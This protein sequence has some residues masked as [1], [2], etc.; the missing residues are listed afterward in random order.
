MAGTHAS[1]GDV[2]LGAL[3]LEGLRRLSV[4]AKSKR[5]GAARRCQGT[6]VPDDNL[7]LVDLDED[8]AALLRRMDGV[9]AKGGA[10]FAAAQA[11]GDL[12]GIEFTAGP[13]RAVASRIA[14]E[15]E[16]KARKAEA[17]SCCRWHRRRTH[18]GGG[19][20]GQGGKGRRQV[21]RQGRRRSHE[22]EEGGG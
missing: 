6:E 19:A 1:H 8:E 18:R 7:A 10:M 21:R 22:L 12:S 5:D 4:E 15:Q 2:N 14:K 13:V 11:A 16:D 9:K 3:S 20:R 17:A